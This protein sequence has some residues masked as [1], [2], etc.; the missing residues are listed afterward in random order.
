M[1]KCICWC[2]SIIELKNALWNIEIHHLPLLYFLQLFP[3][4]SL[5]PL[6]V[7][8]FLLLRL[9]FPTPPPLPLLLTS[10]VAALCNTRVGNHFYVIIQIRL[11]L[12]VNVVS[13]LTTLPSHY[14]PFSPKTPFKCSNLIVFISTISS[15]VPDHIHRLISLICYE[16]RS[17]CFFLIFLKQSPTHFCC[18]ILVTRFNISFDMSI[19]FYIDISPFSFRV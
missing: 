7:F 8:S 19:Y 1:K 11:N 6:L 12:A 14:V 2:L 10:N 5:L 15:P 13:S 16:P 3:P 17:E 18:N 9:L 4:L